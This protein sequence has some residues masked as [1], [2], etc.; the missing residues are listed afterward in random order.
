MLHAQSVWSDSSPQPGGRQVGGAE[1][2]VHQCGG[3]VHVGVVH[4][5]ATGRCTK[6]VCALGE[7]QHWTA[8]V[9]K[10]LD[11]RRQEP[12]CH[13]PVTWEMKARN[14]GE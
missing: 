7:M 4:V 11:Q 5:V 2:R 10:M 14:S 8:S 12:T 3:V 1:G 9:G 13:T 6:D